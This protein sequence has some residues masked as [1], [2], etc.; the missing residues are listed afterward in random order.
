MNGELATK[1]LEIKIDV[2]QVRLLLTDS[3]NAKCIGCH[4]EGQDIVG[5]V[6]NVEWLHKFLSIVKEFNIGEIV[7]SGGEPLLH[8]Q[9]KDI[10][11]LIRSNLDCKISINTNGLIGNKIL[12]IYPLVDEIKLHIE[13]SDPQEYHQLMKLEFGRLVHLLDKLPDYSKLTIC[14]ILRGEEQASGLIDFASQYGIPRVKFNELTPEPPY[15]LEQLEDFLKEKDFSVSDRKSYGTKLSKDVEV[16]LRVCD[17]DPLFIDSKGRLRRGL[18]GSSI[19]LIPLVYEH[20][21]EELGFLLSS[22]EEK[23]YR[24]CIS[25]STFSSLGSMLGIQNNYQYQMDRV[26]ILNET[27]A[28]NEMYFR[29]KDRGGRLSF[30]IKGRSSR[31]EMYREQILSLND[32]QDA[33]SYAETNTRPHI[34]IEKFRASMQLGNCTLYLDR[35]IGLGYFLEIEGKHA[36]FMK[37]RLGLDY[38]TEAL[39]YGDY[40]QMDIAPVVVEMDLKAFRMFE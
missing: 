20:R 4:N 40:I 25:Q 39:P 27:Q 38:H 5:S 3:C 22:V 36:T 18:F 23:E 19:D 11:D 32:L 6:I 8:P 34:S 17:V 9:V 28:P 1:S 10:V 37:K 31:H 30:D 2:P 15:T 33:L 24:W 35:V 21:I 13:S 16:I 29:I 7:L 26:Y 12:D 14:C